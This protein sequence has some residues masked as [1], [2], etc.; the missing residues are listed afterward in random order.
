MKNYD[1]I[2]FD[3]DDTLF[4]FD[5]FSGLQKTFAHFGVVFTQEDYQIYQPI[6]HALWIDYQQGL[7][8]AQELQEARFFEWAKRL[9]ISAQTINKTFMMNMVDICTP[10]NGALSLLN[11]LQGNSKLGIITNGFTELQEARLQRTGLRHYFDLLVISEEVG[12]AK[13]DPGI[14]EHAFSFIDAHNRE[15]ILMVGDNPHSDILGGLNAKI[16]TC[17]LNVHNKPAPQGIIPHYEVSSL[18]E[19]ERLLDSKPMQK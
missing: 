7:I 5:A 6:N 19:L 1:W 4:H 11:K 10:L 13:P 8:N 14:F 16:H 15:Q 17:W 9:K 12:I 18:Y 2:F 3:A